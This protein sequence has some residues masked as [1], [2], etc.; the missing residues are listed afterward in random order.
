MRI[1]AAMAVALMVLTL[2]AGCVLWTFLFHFEEF[3]PV[4]RERV[5]QA[6]RAAL[7]FR[8]LTGLATVGIVAVLLIEFQLLVTS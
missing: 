5:S 4:A 8:T 6:R 1:A 2:V 3:Y 7:L